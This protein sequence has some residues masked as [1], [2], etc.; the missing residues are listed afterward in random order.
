MNLRPAARRV[1]KRARRMVLSEWVAFAI[2][3]GIL[4][5][6]RAEAKTIKIGETTR[7]GVGRL[8]TGLLRQCSKCSEESLLL[9][10]HRTTTAAPLP[11][12]FSDGTVWA[13]QQ[14]R[15]VV[16]R[17]SPRVDSRRAYRRGDAKRARRDVYVCDANV[18]S[19]RLRGCEAQ[20]ANIVDFRS[21]PVQGRKGTSGDTGILHHPQQSVTPSFGLFLLFGR[22]LPR[23]VCAQP[24]YCVG[25]LLHALP[26]SLAEAR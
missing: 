24:L 2:V 19:A 11:P 18:E 9:W 12:A 6:P 14:A 10:F 3:T 20:C 8:A 26:A 5:A 25:A 23:C 4:R 21:T 16:L 17:E 15:V 13:L 1:M 7:S 22:S